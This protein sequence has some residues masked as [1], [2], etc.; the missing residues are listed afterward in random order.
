MYDS[1]KEGKQKEFILLDHAYREY[2]WTQTRTTDSMQL[3][4]GE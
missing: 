2:I 4:N 1:S 3:D